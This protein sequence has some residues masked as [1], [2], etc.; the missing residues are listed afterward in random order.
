M[1]SIILLLKG[2]IIGIGRIIPGVSGSVIAISLGVYEQG[3]DAISNFFKNPIKNI[4]FI[5]PLGMGIIISIIYFSKLIAFLLDN[6]YLFTMTFFI[7]LIIGGIPSLYKKIEKDFNFFNIMVFIVTFS[8]V[9]ALVFA[10]KDNSS[11]GYESWFTLVIIGIIDAATMIIPGISGTAV[12]MLL[13]F[14]EATLDFFASL[15]DISLFIGNI[16]FVLSYT[17]G[18]FIG[19]ITFVKLMEFLLKKHSVS[20]YFAINAFAI[21]SVFMML[22]KV[23]RFNYST[24]EII[25]SGV[26]L[27]IGYLLTKLMGSK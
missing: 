23:T 27:V 24:Y 12:L 9:M 14:Y 3:I 21:S 20:T 8:L 5:I 7:G 4:R 13:G 16:K 18:L 10:T 22:F 17:L 19:G 1:K 6:H 11:S 15:G 2:L 25:L 26:I